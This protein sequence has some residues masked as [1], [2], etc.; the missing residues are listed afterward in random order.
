VRPEI[1]HHPARRY[2]NPDFGL[3]SLNWLELDPDPKEMG[4]PLKNNEIGRSIR[5]VGAF[6]IR[7]S[8]SCHPPEQKRAILGFQKLHIASAACRISETI[9]VSRTSTSSSLNFDQAIAR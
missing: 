4:K 1:G 7:R 8:E 6:W 5:P 2:K 9:S 3:E